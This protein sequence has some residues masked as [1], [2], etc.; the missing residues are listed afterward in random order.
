[1]LVASRIK[2]S[3]AAIKSGMLAAE[4]AAAALAAGRANDA[5][6]AYPEAFR[7]S[8]LYDE[9]TPRATSNRGWPRGCGPAR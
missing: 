9:L 4:A 1:M 3:H 8:W 5:L 2:G 6:S 7:A